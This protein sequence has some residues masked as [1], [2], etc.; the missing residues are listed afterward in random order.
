MHESVVVADGHADVRASAAMTDDTDDDADDGDCDGNRGA[1]LG[2]LSMPTHSLDLDHDLAFG[3][4]DSNVD[5][6]R[7]QILSTP[8]PFP[9]PLPY[10]PSSAATGEPF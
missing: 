2:A 4:I 5:L 1:I 10:P 6:S 8:S 7:T 3:A 9:P